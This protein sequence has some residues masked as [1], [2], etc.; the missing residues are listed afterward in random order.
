[1]RENE[2]LM[3]NAGPVIRYRTAAELLHETEPAQMERLEE[4]LLS[5][6][7]VNAW[8]VNV[9]PRFKAYEMHGSKSEAWENA[10]GKMY[11]FGLRRGIASLDRVTAPYI[12]WL[13]EK[14]SLPKGKR[15]SRFYLMLV[16]A[17]LA[18]TGYSEEETVEWIISERLETIYSFAR[19]GDLSDFYISKER[20]RLPK[21]WRNRPL[22]N[23]D[24]SESGVI[25][26]VHDLNGFLHSRSM[27]EDPSLRE[28]VE[29]I[30]G[31]ILTPEYQKLEPGY[32]I[33]Y[34]RET[35]KYYAAGWSVHLSGFFG[36]EVKGRSIDFDRSNLLRLSML[37]RSRIARGHPWF[38]RSI[39][40]LKVHEDGDGLLTFPR[41]WLP[42][43][44][45]GY[46]ISG[47]RM[48][49]EE[50]RRSRRAITAESTFRYLEITAD[51]G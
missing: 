47:K 34:E 27:M 21:V 18:M 35:K 19:R 44:G 31:F 42:N 45:T 6:G 43:L 14:L 12:A 5:T 29:T 15:P 24:L 28:R 7:M 46:W 30:V 3:A 50:N 41:E 10:M 11:D 2:W 32:G 49:L 16:A 9:V 36:Q 20:Y 48:A 26:S 17:F 25:P 37:S 40:R 1:M 22:I 13:E 51:K 33:L 38:R 4:E 39:E 8:R 23:P